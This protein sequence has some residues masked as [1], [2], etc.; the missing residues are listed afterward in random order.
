MDIFYTTVKALNQA[1]SVCCT[2]ILFNGIQNYSQEILIH[3]IKQRSLSA[4]E[5]IL[6]FIKSLSV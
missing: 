6:D 2:P 5:T 1:T 4:P 3:G